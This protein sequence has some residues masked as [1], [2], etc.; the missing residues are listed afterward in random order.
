MSSNTGNDLSTRPA[1]PCPRCPHRLS[2][3][4]THEDIS[5][6]DDQVDVPNTLKDRKTCVLEIPPPTQEIAKRN[7]HRQLEAQAGHPPAYHESAAD[8][9]VDK[10]PERLKEKARAAESTGDEASGEAE[11]VVQTRNEPKTTEGQEPVH[12]CRVCGGYFPDP[13]ADNNTN[14]SSWEESDPAGDLAIC[15]GRHGHE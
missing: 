4:S 15:D 1:R 7:E 14:L 6:P 9:L 8:I 10:S 2:D 3:L 5:R 13:S 12:L 11:E